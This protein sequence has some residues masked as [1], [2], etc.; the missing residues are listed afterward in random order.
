VHSIETHLNEFVE[1]PDIKDGFVTLPDR[2]GL[3]LVWHEEAIA[4]R[5]G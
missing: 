5:V 4:R 2:P 1:P 3:G